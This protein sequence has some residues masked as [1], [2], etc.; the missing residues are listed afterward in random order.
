MY[1]GNISIMR[2]EYYYSFFWYGILMFLRKYVNYFLSVIMIT[3][4]KKI[5]QLTR[6]ADTLRYLVQSLE[7]LKFYLIFNSKCLAIDKWS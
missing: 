6:H 2:R 1:L 5:T 3:L 4:W 7:S